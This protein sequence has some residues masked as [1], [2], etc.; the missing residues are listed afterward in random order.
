MRLEGIAKYDNGRL[1]PLK[2]YSEAAQL[3]NEW[4]SYKVKWNT[5]G[6]LHQD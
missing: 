6:F 2:M 5:S 3:N 1:S 4:T